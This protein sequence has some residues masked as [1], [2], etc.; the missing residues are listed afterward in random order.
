MA[1]DQTDLATQLEQQTSLMKMKT[2]TVRDIHTEVKE[3]TNYTEEA[4]TIEGEE[5]D[6]HNMDEAMHK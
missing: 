6:T 2:K 1:S 5:L 4:S 3:A